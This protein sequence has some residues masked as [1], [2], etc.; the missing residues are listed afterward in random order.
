MKNIDL[1][2]LWKA[3]S[4]PTRRHILDLLRQS[5]RTT[6][7]ISKVFAEEM[8]RYAVMKHLTVLEEANLISIRRKGRERYNHLNAVPLQHMYERWLRPYESEWATSL[9]NLK[10]H[11]EGATMT[12]TTTAI[13]PQVYN[14]EQE[15]KID[16]PVEEAFAALLDINGWW[17]QRFSRIPN[18]LRL[19]AKVGG[20]FWE[21]LDGSE[22]NGVLW[23]MVTSIK[24]N[25]HVKVQGSI[26]MPGAIL[27]SFTIC[28]NEQDDGTTLVTLSHQFM[29]DVPD[30]YEQGF[31]EGW[32]FN[33]N[34]MKNLVE[35]GERLV[36][37]MPE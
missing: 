37:P 5:P 27:G 1:N 25:D 34:A 2:S 22:E 3:L 29:G 20:R 14:I 18:S 11:A 33:L 30:S 28:T 6:G 7:E 9:I 17:S 12:D 26:G 8:S 4:D 24:T 13:Q 36:R 16:A 19:E 10:N 15:I 21:T 31:G 32:V 35:N 23:G